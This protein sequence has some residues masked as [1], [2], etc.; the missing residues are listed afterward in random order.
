MYSLL[1]LAAGA[2]AAVQLAI[3]PSR[4]PVAYALSAVAAAVYLAGAIALRRDG[5]RARRIAAG[6]CAFELSGVLVVGALS[7]AAP[8]DFP[9]ASVWSGFGSG[10]GHVP[11]VLPIGGL[12]WL[13]ADRAASRARPHVA[14]S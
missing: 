4:A 9:D 1:A 3:D 11:L 8:A 13:R 6:I 2:R 12:W 14:R 7:L 10:Y 5:R